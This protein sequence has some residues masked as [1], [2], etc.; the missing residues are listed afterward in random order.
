MFT[1]R[2]YAD[3][4]IDEF[5]ALLIRKG[6]YKDAKTLNADLLKSGINLSL[7]QLMD[8]LD[9]LG[10]YHINGL[11]V[12]PATSFP[13]NDIWDTIKELY[14]IHG[15]REVVHDNQLHLVVST[16]TAELFD[17]YFSML[18]NYWH[19]K[20]EEILS[21]TRG[22]TCVVVYFAGPMSANAAYRRLKGIRGRKTLEESRHAQDGK[23]ES[24]KER[25]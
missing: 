6:N 22:T 8:T 23:P 5:V 21:V 16:G 19:T 7:N 14:I 25:V 4:N 3:K 9:R 10:V 15:I 12:Y 2:G 20:G 24:S 1:D 17:H 13:R 11:F 18:I